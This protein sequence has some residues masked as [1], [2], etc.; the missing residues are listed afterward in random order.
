MECVALMN[1][2]LQDWRRQYDVRS[3]VKDEFCMD[4]DGRICFG[5]TSL[6]VPAVCLNTRSAD[7]DA[8]NIQFSFENGVEIGLEIAWPE[9]M[10]PMVRAVTVTFVR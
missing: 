2:V 8:E 6:F 5:A 10:P 1:G 4:D 7:F 3:M 9:E